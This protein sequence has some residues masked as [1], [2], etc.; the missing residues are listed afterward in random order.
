[1]H[2]PPVV[3]WPGL[4]NGMYQVSNEGMAIVSLENMSLGPYHTCKVLCLS[5]LTVFMVVLYVD[6]LE[7]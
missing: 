5:L 1:M 6:A 7:E 2:W 3:P 4:Y